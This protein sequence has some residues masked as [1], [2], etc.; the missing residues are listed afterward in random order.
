ML[1][2]EAKE[3]LKNNGYLVERSDLYD[4]FSDRH[5]TYFDWQMDNNIKNRSMS[6]PTIISLKNNI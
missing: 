1:L 4:R 6:M 2:S 3:I 5:Q